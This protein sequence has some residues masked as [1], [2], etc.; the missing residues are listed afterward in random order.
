MQISFK[1]RL[2]IVGFSSFVVA[3]VRWVANSLTHSDLYLQNK[4][5]NIF[6]NKI[7]FPKVLLHHRILIIFIFV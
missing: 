5:F 6:N 2:F 1:F 4:K 7:P 3:F